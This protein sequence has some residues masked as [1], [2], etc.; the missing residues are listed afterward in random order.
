MISSPP[1]CC[2]RDEDQWDGA[3]ERKRLRELYEQDGWLH[4]SMSS[5]ST[6][7]RRRRVIRRLGLAANAEAFQERRTI[8]SHYMDLAKL[9][10]QAAL[11]VH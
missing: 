1:V 7:E 4:G 5:L 11:M 3:A 9:V 10:S 6:K 2:K 8:I